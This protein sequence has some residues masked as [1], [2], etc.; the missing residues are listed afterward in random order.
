[1]FM[2]KNLFVMLLLISSAAFSAIVGDEQNGDYRR[3]YDAGYLAGYECGKKPDCELKTEKLI[4][5]GEHSYRS[6]CNG[7][8]DGLMHGFSEGRSER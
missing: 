8:A 1:M 6:G 5:P 2:K 4:C 7:M 3:N